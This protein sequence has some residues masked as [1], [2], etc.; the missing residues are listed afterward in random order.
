[1]T[2]QPRQ[3][4]DTWAEQA[5]C[6]S[7][8]QTFIEGEINRAGIAVHTAQVELEHCRDVIADQHRQILQL[9]AQLGAKKGKKN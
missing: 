3:T 8:L 6:D 5:Q 7:S 9:Q 1:V 2:Q 4:G